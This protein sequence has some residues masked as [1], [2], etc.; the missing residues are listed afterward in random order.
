VRNAH[1]ERPMW[2][3]LGRDWTDGRHFAVLTDGIGPSP[4]YDFHRERARYARNRNRNPVT[5]SPRPASISFGAAN[6]RRYRRPPT[7]GKL[8]KRCNGDRS[9]DRRLM[10]PGLRMN[11][12]LHMPY[13]RAGLVVTLLRRRHSLPTDAMP[14]CEGATDVERRAT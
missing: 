3:T 2:A 5:L 14:R 9:F 10:V 6:I 1:S 4:T 7:R 13:P 12:G 8:L 11:S